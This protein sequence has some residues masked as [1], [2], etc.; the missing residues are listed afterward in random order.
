MTPVQQQ[1]YYQQQQ[2]QWL[3]Y[4]QQYNQWFAKYGEQVM[5]PL[6]KFSPDL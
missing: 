2:Q 5:F 3:I 4:Q 1:A 6:K